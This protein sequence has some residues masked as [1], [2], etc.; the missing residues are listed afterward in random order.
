MQETREKYEKL[1]EEN[2]SLKISFNDNKE[3]LEINLVL[4]RKK[5]FIRKRN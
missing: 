4:E 1:I 5:N 3:I 2:K